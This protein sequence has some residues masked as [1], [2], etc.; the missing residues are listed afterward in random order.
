MSIF[1]VLLSGCANPSSSSDNETSNADTNTLSAGDTIVLSTVDGNTVNGTLVDQDGDGNLDGVD[2]DGDTSTLELVFL[3][4]ASAAAYA[5]ANASADAGTVYTIDATGDGV[6]DFYLIIQDGSTGTAELNLQEDGSGTVVTITL[7][8]DGNISGVDT[9]GDGQSD[10]T[11]TLIT[12]GDAKAITAFSFIAEDNTELS[13]DVEG[14][15]AGIGSTISITV[16]AGTNVTALIPTISI[17]GSSLNPA[18]GI[19]TDFSSPVTYTVTAGDE[20]T[21]D[22]SVTVTVA[23]IDAKEI[24]AFSFIA[25]D[26][27]ELSADVTAN[28]NGTAITATVPYDTDLMALVATFTTT[29]DSVTVNSTEQVSGDATND[30]SNPVIYTVTAVDSSTQEY[31][32]SVTT[33][34]ADAKEITAFSFTA[35]ANSGLSSDVTADINEPYITATVPYGP[36][37]TVLVATFTSTGERVIVDYTV[38]I[39]GTTTND[40]SSAVL[41][42]VIA[43]EAPWTSYDVTV[44]ETAGVV[45][46]SVTYTTGS[47]SFDMVYVPGGLTFPTDIDD[48]PTADV[49]NNFLI[50]Q[51]E[52]TYELWEAVRTWAEASADTLY[53]FDNAGRQGSTGALTDFHPVTTINWR[54]AMVW[55][56]ALTEYYNAQNGTSLTCVYYYDPSFTTPIRDSKDDDSH[57]T[58]TTGDYT[59]LVN[60]N[61]GGFDDPYVK[62]DATGFRLLTSNEWELAARYIDDAND[63][64]EITIAEY[65]SYPGSYA[66]GATA[67]YTDAAATG[68]VAVYR[69]G[70]TSS[71][72]TV[73][74]KSPNAL[75]LYDMS[76]NVWEMTFD[77]HPLAIGSCRGRRGGAYWVGA[78]AHV[79]L[80]VVDSGSP[81][82]G[83]DRVG[84]RFA[85]TP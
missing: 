3:E 81:W 53:T 77:W 58:E 42:E 37:V 85:R 62:P 43:P 54:D 39:S 7:D 40:F 9:D 6:A 35:A 16:P 75:G 83:S 25:D 13:E 18:S 66:S 84:F 26:N 29:G 68:L 41:Y 57:S 31:T 28:I 1:I 27:T 74:S 63:D 24:T 50:G 56:N 38:Q 10:I 23:P 22:F 45:G 69:D 60:P 59:G 11:G 70:N 79:Q 21:L 14:L 55:M 71:T 4:S 48:D 52:V 73:K 8:S 82:N 2:L 19:E 5:P 34:P 15:I 32:V 30:F 51:T 72:A 49:A 78:T 67:D 44:T 12:S 46:D 80:G 64:G 76:G 65:E 17:I 33:T 20:T 61:A 47:V 36:D